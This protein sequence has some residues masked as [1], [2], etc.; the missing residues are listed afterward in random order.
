MDQEINDDEGWY[1]TYAFNLYTYFLN[2]SIDN[3]FFAFFK[4]KYLTVE[5]DLSLFIKKKG[6]E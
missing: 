6:V 1:E 5:T 3:K 4:K 2:H